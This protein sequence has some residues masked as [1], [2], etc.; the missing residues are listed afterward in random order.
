MGM[1]SK[2]PLT[3]TAH[4]TRGNKRTPPHLLGG[5]R[6]APTF[7]LLTPYSAAHVGVMSPRPLRIAYGRG[8][9][10]GSLRVITPSFWS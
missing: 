3:L 7:L 6:Y 2:Q 4:R 5:L 1:G 10:L 9:E 8:C